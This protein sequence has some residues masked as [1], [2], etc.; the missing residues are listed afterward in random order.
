MSG[1]SKWATT[2]HKKA[3]TD[4]KRGKIFTKLA[5]EITVAAKLGGSDP[6]GNPRLRTAV[7]KAKGVS[8]P[9]ENIKR[10]IQKGTGELPG[11]SYEEVMYEGYGP[12]GVAVIVDVMTDNRNRTVSEIRN[13]FSKAGGNMGEAGC[14]AWMF[15]K[16]GYLVINRSKVDEDKLMTLALEAG[17]E[18][19]QTEE[20]NYVVTTPPHDFEKVKKVLEDAGVAPDVAEI[21]MI[22]QTY[23]KLDSKEAQQMLRLIETL[24]DNDDVQNVYANF[25]IPEEIMNAV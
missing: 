19:M 15:H 8:L 3:A 25:D 11:V 10:A 16:K 5:K 17:A 21:T 4:A 22:P 2:K 23:V 1:H 24:E 9:A 13:I 6:N 7:A 20:E 18:D 14:V 12:A